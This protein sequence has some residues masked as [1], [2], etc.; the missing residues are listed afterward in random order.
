MVIEFHRSERIYYRDDRIF[1]LIEFCI[2]QASTIFIYFP[3]KYIRCDVSYSILGDF[4]NY[5]GFFFTISNCFGYIY[6]EFIRYFLNFH[7]NVK[8]PRNSVS[9]IENSQNSTFT[10][11][12]SVIGI[13]QGVC[14]LL[15]QDYLL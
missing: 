15:W 11:L 5:S 6:I 14:L 4:N 2:L 13:Y 1:K 3:E 8:F 7:F 9:G 12:S 10:V